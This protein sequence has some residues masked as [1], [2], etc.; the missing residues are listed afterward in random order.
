VDEEKEE[1][2]EDSDQTPLKGREATVL[3]YQWAGETSL[4]F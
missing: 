1:S 3:S 4:T 2:Y